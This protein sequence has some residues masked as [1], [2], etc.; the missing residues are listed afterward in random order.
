M[1]ATS[2]VPPRNTSETSRSFHTHR[3]W[4]MPNAASAGVRSGRRILKKIVTCPAPST[5]A[6]SMSSPGSSRMKLWMRNV[7]SGSAKMVCDNQTDQ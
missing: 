6:A 1:G 4:K 7:A 5:R 2:G 3:N